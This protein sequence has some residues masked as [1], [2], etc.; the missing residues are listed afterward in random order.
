V[1]R[2][3]LAGASE[4]EIATLTGHSLANVREILDRH[5]L[6]R[7]VALAESAIRKLEAGVSGQ[8]SRYPPRTKQAE[9]SQTDLQTGLRG[10]TV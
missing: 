6:H 2:L 10:P 1:T 8:L 9:S 5:Y 3:A 4:P 7:D